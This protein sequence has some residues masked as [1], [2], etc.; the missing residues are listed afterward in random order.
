MSAVEFGDFALTIAILLVA[1]HGPVC[2]V[3]R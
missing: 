2:G 1:V 3:L